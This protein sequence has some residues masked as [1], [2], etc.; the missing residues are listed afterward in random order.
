ME[1]ET[2]GTES[3]IVRDSR[4][5]STWLVERDGM[6]KVSGIPVEAC[7]ARGRFQPTG[8]RDHEGVPSLTVGQRV[9]SENTKHERQPRD[10]LV[11]LWRGRQQPD[12]KSAC[13]HGAS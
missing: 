13:S 7:C 8:L 2:E 11:R 3:Q 12:G 5:R 1:S 9:Q 4:D 6:V 10:S